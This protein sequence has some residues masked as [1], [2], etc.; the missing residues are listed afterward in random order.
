VRR[1]RAHRD[2]DAAYATVTR[3]TTLARAA[4]DKKGLRRAAFECLDRIVLDRK[5]RL[6]S[7][8]LGGLEPSG[9]TAR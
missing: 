7:V 5:V 9:R 4:I 2:G 3:R 8:R 6:L 1:A